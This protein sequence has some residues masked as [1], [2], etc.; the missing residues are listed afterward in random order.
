MCGIGAGALIAGPLSETV[1]RNPVYFASL[2]LFM[3]FILGA[4]LS[5]SIEVQLVCRFFAGF[6]GESPLSTIGGSIG[7]LWDPLD[8]LIAFPIFAGMHHTLYF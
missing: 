3:F 5:Q 1:G 8:R 6:C 7:D 4:G 2:I